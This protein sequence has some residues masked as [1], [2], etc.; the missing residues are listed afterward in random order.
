[1]YY[2]FAD[3]HIGSGRYSR[4]LRSAT[5]TGEHAKGCSPLVPLY[6]SENKRAHVR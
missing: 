4:G 1:M 5:G 6:H 2:K 3:L